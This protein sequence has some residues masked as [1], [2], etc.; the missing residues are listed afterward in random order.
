MDG[1]TRVRLRAV[2]PRRSPLCPIRL[3]G[4]VL[5]TRSTLAPHSLHLAPHS[6]RSQV[7][8]PAKTT[9]NDTNC[10]TAAN[11]A[12]AVAA[13]AAAESAAEVEAI[14]ASAMNGRD[15]YTVNNLAAA[16]AEAPSKV[17]AANDPVTAN[18]RDST[19]GTIAGVVITLFTITAI[20]RAS[21][22]LSLAIAITSFTPATHAASFTS[23]VLFTVDLHPSLS[24]TAE[25][26]LSE[27]GATLLSRSS[28]P[29]ASEDGR[30]KAGGAFG[31][32][33]V[34]GP[35]ALASEKHCNPRDAI[36]ED[37]LGL[38]LSFSEA[39]RGASYSALSRIDRRHF[40]EVMQRHESLLRA[41]TVLC[42]FPAAAC[43]L[44][45]PFNKSLLV[46]AAHRFDYGRLSLPLR[47][48]I[49]ENLRA[50]AAVPGNLVAA[51]S[52]YE[53]EYIRYYTG[54]RVMVIPYLPLPFADDG[55]VASSPLAADPKEDPA[56][57][58]AAKTVVARASFVLNR[59]MHPDI[60]GPLQAEAALHDVSL[61]RME[62]AFEANG[63]R[64]DWG[65]LAST[66]L[67]VV[68]VPYCVQNAFTGELYRSN[69]PVF[70]PSLPLL[71]D[72]HIRYGLL[73]GD[74]RAS[75]EICW[76]W[77]SGCGET[78]P[79]FVGEPPW[80]GHGA[81][82]GESSPEE[83]MA[84][85][86]LW[87]WLGRID[88]YQVFS[89][90]IIFFDSPRDLAEKLEEVA[91]SPGRAQTVAV[92][93]ARHNA[94]LEGEARA[95][96]GI[97]LAMTGPGRDTI[98]AGGEGFDRSTCKGGGVCDSGRQGEGLGGTSLLNAT[99]RRTPLRDIPPTFEAGMRIYGITDGAT[100]QATGG[101]APS[102]ASSN[103]RGVK[104]GA[105]SFLWS[106]CKSVFHRMLFDVE[107]PSKW[108]VSPLKGGER[109]GELEEDEERQQDSDAGPVSGEVVI[110]ASFPAQLQPVYS[111]QLAVSGT[112]LE[113]WST[114][115]DNTV[116]VGALERERS[117]QATY[118]QAP[119]YDVSRLAALFVPRTS[120][121]GCALDLNVSICFTLYADMNTRVA[122]SRRRPIS[123]PAG[124]DPKWIKMG[125]ITCVS[126]LMASSIPRPAPFVLAAVGSYR[127]DTR[128]VLPGQLDESLDLF[129]SQTFHAVQAGTRA[130][131]GHVV[132]VH[133]G[134]LQ[135][136][137]LARYDDRMQDLS[138]RTKGP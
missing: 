61:E 99:V 83:D 91:R 95:A 77:N 71:V 113:E 80:M 75:Q 8:R 98:V 59:N 43:E 112:E 37:T 79:P 48:R 53:A 64:F 97:A 24:F 46:V 27:H 123:E 4:Y 20:A 13:A 94:L 82:P 35:A 96:W 58:T 22:R 51:T 30:K 118:E 41:D 19:C 10:Y 135:P 16:A 70:A 12:T 106:H 31:T 15:S 101:G 49:V 116:H 119:D 47:Q 25:R 122:G 17:K 28:F 137:K 26:A 90:N 5:R 85:E 34:G 45:M 39:G 14:K 84:R 102:E 133:P 33:A 107:H 131:H 21:L 86:A 132:A 127:V 108:V 126:M 36:S 130:A 56:A 66:H 136:L 81:L 69:I 60:A 32:W 105:D 87:T 111:I 74:R 54:L 55:S 2:T 1:Y 120:L 124:V 128:I 72:W 125:E 7:T 110:S 78:S 65:T 104:S 114:T 18:S 129:S 109:E 67:G 42:M 68:L 44:F 138:R 63:G 89:E 52:V 11:P 100:P 76:I 115:G 103:V 117:N 40:F 93:Q 92:Q 6:L 57:A 62:R 73:S 134:P 23:R 3:L 9:P 29:C 38:A 50:I 121:I 88:I